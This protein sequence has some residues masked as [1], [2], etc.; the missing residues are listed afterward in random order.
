MIDVSASSMRNYWLHRPLRMAIA[1]QLGGTLLCAALIWVMPEIARVPLWAACLQG[2]SC[3]IAAHALKAPWWWQALNLVFAPLVVL[4]LGLALPPW[5]W[6]AAFIV[7][8]LMFWRTDVSRVPLYLSNQATADALANMLPTTPVFLL[9][10]GCGD[11]RLLRQLS[12]ARPAAQL[13]GVEHAPLPWLV[14]RVMSGQ[15]RNIDI[16]YGNLWA[17]SFAPFDVVYAFLSPA[18]MAKLWQKACAEMRPGTLVVSNSFAIPGA[19]P[20]RS[21][22]VDDHRQT[23]LLIYRVPPAETPDPDERI[24]KTP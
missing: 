18:P 4:A 6:L 20:E 8:M 16:R 23:S 21:I 5:V 22:Q 1:T 2:A 10:A 24:N 17:Q 14:A 12:G 9:D 11:G 3:V 15:Q 7:L 13:V 19:A